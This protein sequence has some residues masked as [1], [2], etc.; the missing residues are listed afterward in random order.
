MYSTSVL[1][2]P[3]E[4]INILQNMPSIAFLQQE[5]APAIHTALNSDQVEAYTHN[6]PSRCLAEHSHLSAFFDAI[7]T[8]LRNDAELSDHCTALGIVIYLMSVASC[9]GARY[10]PLRHRC[11]TKA[12]AGWG[13]TEPAGPRQFG[14]HLINPP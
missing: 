11:A 3:W 7:R 13:G 9:A 10:V 2:A 1:A 12:I 6:L 14:A 5:N 8:D 4:S